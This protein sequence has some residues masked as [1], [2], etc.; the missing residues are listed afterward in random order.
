ML[1]LV[2]Q[3]LVANKRAKSDNFTLLYMPTNRLY[4]QKLSLVFALIV[5][6][7]CEG[8]SCRREGADAVFFRPS[9]MD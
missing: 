3:C 1:S 4:G 9:K 2:K 8:N 7:N 5:A 6:N